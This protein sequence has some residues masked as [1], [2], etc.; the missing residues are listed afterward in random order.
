MAGAV[1]QNPRG[2]RVLLVIS[3][4]EYGGTQ[5]QVAELVNNFDDRRVDARICS[6]SHYVPLGARLQRPERLHVV[7][8]LFRFDLSVVPR[9]ARMLRAF[10][11]DVVHGFLFD[12]EIA[13]RLAGRL[14]ATSLVVGSERNANYRLKPQQL[15]AYRLTRSMVDL[16][17]AN[18][19]AG[20]EF[21]REKLGQDPSVYR[22]VHNGVDVERFA[23]GDGL[24]VRRE[25][26]IAKDE[27][28]VGMFASFKEQKN[29]P[30]F[31]AAARQ[32]LDRR[33]NTRLLLVGE[34]LYDGMHGS[35][36]Y[37]A[38][39]DGVV[40]DLGLRDRCL[41]LGNRLDVERLYRACDLTVLPSLHEGM[42]NVL[43]E[44]MASGVPVVATAVSDN[45]YVVRDGETGYVVPLGDSEGLA[46]RVVRLLQ[47]S[48]LRSR[49]ARAAREWIEE[50][51]SCSRLA[52]KMEGVYR[53]SLRTRTR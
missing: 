41:F 17:V 35:A 4:M 26:G 51:F 13:S 20:A 15:A 33:P 19:H 22:V 16:V 50:E 5:R 8:K 9:L 47:D 12:A 32:V 34:Q 1:A 14:A 6:L 30:L 37:R 43:L 11:A 40:A 27:G 48:A 24:V 29:H 25:L 38:R 44:S 39:M 46:D 53:E 21:N 7:R 42:P 45:P 49:M 10:R 36:D 52:L 31:F 23:P 2:I 28:V 18:S 3:N